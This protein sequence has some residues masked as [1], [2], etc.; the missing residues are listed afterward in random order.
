MSTAQVKIYIQKV[1][2][3]FSNFLGIT[4]QKL[5]QVVGE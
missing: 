3:D 4:C 5:D 1:C 2:V